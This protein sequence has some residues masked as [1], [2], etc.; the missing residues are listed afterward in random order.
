MLVFGKNWVGLLK[1]LLQISSIWRKFGSKTAQMEETDMPRMKLNRTNIDKHTPFTRKGAVEYWDSGDGSVKGFGLR[2]GMSSKT[3]F[4]QIDVPDPGAKGAKKHRTLKATLGKYGELTPEQARRKASD[5]I[6]ELRAAKTTRTEELLTL[7]EMI[8]KYLAAKSL[9]SATVDI[10]RKQL[11]VKF[12]GWM[13]MKLKDVALLH[14]ELVVQRFNLVKQQYGEM[15]A[16]TA[17]AKLQSVLNYA[18]VL[19][20]DSVQRNPC[21]VLSRAKL[22][23][24]A[25]SRVDCLKGADFKQFY[26]G[27]QSFNDATR[28][29]LLFCLYQGCRNRE[30]AAL[31][32]EHV[33][34]DNGVLRIADTK[35]YA[36][37]HVPL[38]SQSVEILKRR[39]NQNPAGC[40][41]VFST[42]KAYLSKTGHVALTSQSLREKTG[43]SITVHGLRRSFVDIADNKLKL[44]REDVDRL[45]NHVDR[46]V[47]GRHYSHKD[48]E[49][50]RDDLR[51]I[52]NEIERLML[53]GVG[54]KVTFLFDSQ[55]ARR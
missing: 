55:A 21:A 24:K 9:A 22:W 39:L 34:I 52:C 37:L 5:T 36:A 26:D 11:P 6:N 40:P 50:L 30:A 43:L 3:F 47:T 13:E 17:F 49:D 10:Y 35:N 27:I 7:S 19:F 28:D 23:P 48:I 54:A 12:E 16:S 44:R 46:S 8:E 31:K 1:D 33:D 4:V 18:M 42:A 25:K 38:S 51:K 41:F 2:V 14:P 32:W 15:A 20:P 45:I 29:A 53:N